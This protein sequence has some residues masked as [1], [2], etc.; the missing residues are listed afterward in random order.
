MR[1][2][3]YRS[4]SGVHSSGHTHLPHL[5]PTI[6]LSSLLLTDAPKDMVCTSKCRIL[7]ILQRIFH[8]RLPTLRHCSDFYNSISGTE[9]HFPKSLE[10][11]SKCVYE[12]IRRLQIRVVDSYSSIEYTII[13]KKWL[14]NFEKKSNSFF[15]Y[16][17]LQCTVMSDKFTEFYIKPQCLKF[18]KQFSTIDFIF[19]RFSFLQKNNPSEL[20]QNNLNYLILIFKNF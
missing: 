2:R 9:L 7:D 6:C 1:T 15:F 14:E 11:Q 19:W 10:A 5:F 3:C 12:T 8:S 16:S 18:I 17:P 13:K 4:S 20:I